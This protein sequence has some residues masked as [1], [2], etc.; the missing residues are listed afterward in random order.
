M[1]WDLSMTK[2]KTREKGNYF[3]RK[4]KCMKRGLL[5][6]GKSVQYLYSKRQSEVSNLF[7]SYINPTFFKMK[8]KSDQVKGY[9]D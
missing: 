6:V 4:L 2:S 7:N 8:Q 3:S 5:L 1:S 9:I